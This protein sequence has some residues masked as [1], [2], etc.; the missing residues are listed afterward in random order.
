MQ[1]KIVA[2]KSFKRALENYLIYKD[3]VDEQQ[4][5]FEKLNFIYKKVKKISSSKSFIG[6]KVSYSNS[7]NLQYFTFQKHVILFVLSPHAIELKYFVPAVR[8]K[9]SL[10]DL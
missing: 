5:S 3:S 7:K 8:I 6:K 1:R 9:K 10:S 2:S 4:H